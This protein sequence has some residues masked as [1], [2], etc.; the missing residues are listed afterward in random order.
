MKKFAVRVICLFMMIILLFVY[1]C[2]LDNSEYLR[3]NNSNQSEEGGSSMDN[4]TNNRDISDIDG[5]A[6]E[7]QYDPDFGLFFEAEDAAV[8]TGKV[9]IENTH[10]GFSGKGYLVGIE[11]EEDTV[12]FYV[13]IPESGFYDLN[14]ISSSYDGY[15]EN[16]VYVNGEF[17]GVAKVEGTDFQ[18]SILKRVYLKAGK[19]EIKMTKSWG[20]IRLD[21]LK[22]TASSSNEEDI[23]KVSAKL[24]DPEATDRVK[25]LMQYLCDMYGKYII[26]GQYSDGGIN[27]PE[28]KAIYNATGKYPAILGL[29]F[30]DYTPSR[31]TYGTTSKAVE[32]AIEFDKL[33][34]IV[35]FCWHWNA[36]EPYLYNTSENPWWSG[37]Y[38]KA[39]NI[40]LKAIMN[41]EDPQGYELLLRDIDEIAKCLKRLQEADVPVL[42]RPLH[43]ASGG[44]FW[45]GASGAEAYIKL[46]RLLFDRL[47]K[48][49]CIHN[50]IWVWN[51]Q[52]PNWYPGDEYVD[53]I[54]IDIYPGERIYSPHT[55]KFFEMAEWPVGRRIIALTENGCLFDTDLAFR[56]NAVWSYF[57]TWSGD[58]VS[59]N[60]TDTLSEKYTE[61][62][63]FGK[64]YNHEKVITL[65]ELPDLRNYGK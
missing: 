11:G 20:W 43:E 25:R 58:F 16:N 35:T 33:G 15:K 3:D 28:F 6:V 10:L 51:G 50:L 1:G 59:L 48:V 60:K 5:A 29:D 40:N 44:W 9:R 49:H 37:F 12:T 61:K 19:N 4:A 26:S 55:S 42:W 34:G 22:V 46:Y 47:T 2:G 62:Y 56:D 64:V 14:F 18:D 54:G 31:I 32:Y 57:G 8:T 52:H 39:T 63:M 36:P 65:D 21:A 17:V 13:T 38:T 53:I 45:W 27:G 41:G 30:I 23:Y 24:V 7:G